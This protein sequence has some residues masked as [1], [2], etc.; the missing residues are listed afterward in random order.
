MY[1]GRG[2]II[3]ALL[4]SDKFE[5]II[6]DMRTNAERVKERVK[7]AQASDE[8]KRELGVY[9]LWREAMDLSPSII[10]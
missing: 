1:A 9:F 5:S 7:L 3:S 4:L 8:V 6:D 10:Y 2:R